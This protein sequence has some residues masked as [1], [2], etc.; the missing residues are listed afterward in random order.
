MKQIQQ[1]LLLML[2]CCLLGMATSIAQNQGNGQGSNNCPGDKD[3][4]G[5]LDVNDCNPNSKEKW[6]S[7]TVYVDR[8]GDG[9]TKDTVICYGESI[10]KEFAL[11]P[12]GADCD[13]NNAE[14]HPGATEVC[15]GID[16]DCDGEIDEDKRTWYYDADGDGRATETRVAC[17]SPGTGWTTVVLPIGDNCPNVGNANQ[18]DKDGN[19]TGDACETP[20]IS[21]KP[22]TVNLCA[23]QSFTFSDFYSNVNQVGVL[24]KLSSS[25][26][27][28]Y[29]TI[30]SVP[31]DR[32]QEEIN[33]NAV[34]G[35]FSAT[36]GPYSLSSGTSGT[37][38]QVYT[39][40][41]DANFNNVYDAGDV[42]GTPVTLQYT[43][44]A[45]PTWYQD[46]DGDG[47]AGATKQSCTEP[48]GGNWS[49][50][51]I[52]EG[53]CDDQT[54]SVNPGATEVC[55]GIDDNCNGDI[56]EGVTT[57]YYEDADGDGF[58]NPNSSKK[59]CSAPQGYVT[60]NSDCDDT[61]TTYADADGDGF[62]FGPAIACGTVTNNSD[63]DDTKTT[64]ADA[65]NDGFGSGPAI[66]C[67][68]VTN[69]TDN[70]PSKA[71][72]D[73]ADMD[74]DGQGDTCDEDIDGDDV[75]NNADCAPLDKKN[76]KWLV[77]HKGKTL[78]VDKAG[79]LDHVGHGDALGSCQTV[80]KVSG[81][82]VMS[83]SS[84]AEELTVPGLAKGIELKAF[85]N[86]TSSYFTLNLRSVS[87]EK[88][89]L[90]VYDLVGR[91]VY[92]INGSANETYQFG[93][94]FPKGNYLVR[95]LQADKQAT[96]K[97]TKQ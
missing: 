29:G 54:A 43:I 87:S 80:T 31:A 42:L 89:Q 19:G 4:D 34:A 3:C 40:Y 37:I 41:Y 76:N 68:T 84:T 72:V 23:G 11:E 97:L 65:D 56:D 2:V 51:K 85:P 82:G 64:Y 24:E 91:E 14:V 38:T 55:N 61:K 60:D 5:V 20:V 32:P 35:F 12:S 30:Y 45:Q 13:D 39:P 86:P 88:V 44:T 49:T 7:A 94:Q 93:E 81:N 47:Y 27:V 74:N 69:N 67:G 1:K 15:N 62:G 33:P 70:C 90:K 9:Y 66:A 16:D 75:P 53:D 22:T 10:P 26:N 46:K 58:G 92:S 59:A 6:R 50:T 18:Q 95:V 83:G 8:D 57:T 36:Y 25:G 48:E 21:F 52:P 63:C 96:V 71:N 17:E 77:C 73:Q 79:M 28:V 78:C